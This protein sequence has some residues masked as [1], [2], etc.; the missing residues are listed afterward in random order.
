MPT[1]LNI[2]FDIFEKAL[3]NPLSLRMVCHGYDKPSSH[4]Q[5]VE[6]IAV[7]FHPVCIFSAGRS[8]FLCE[9]NVNNRQ[10]IHSLVIHS[11]CAWVICCG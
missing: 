4:Q 8:A 6:M 9:D 7:V 5:V 10:G 11:L 3:K 2:R 1:A